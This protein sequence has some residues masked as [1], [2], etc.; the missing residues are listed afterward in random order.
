M[1]RFDALTE[2]DEQA[3][4]NRAT[5]LIVPEKHHSPAPFPEKPVAKA[6]SEPGAN[7]DTTQSP[8]GESTAA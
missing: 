7:A 4:Q 1:G 3:P 6:G 2:L 5:P 8:A